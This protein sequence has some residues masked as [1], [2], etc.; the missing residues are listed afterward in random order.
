MRLHVPV[1]YESTG[2]ISV[3]YSLLLVLLVRGILC[4]YSFLFDIHLSFDKIIY[5][6]SQLFVALEVIAYLPSNVCE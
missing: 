3:L 6:H 2:W 1:T 4:L 5:V